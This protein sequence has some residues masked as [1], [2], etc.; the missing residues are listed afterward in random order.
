MI[1]SLT[2]SSSS[3]SDAMGGQLDATNN[4]LKEGDWNINNA[5][6]SSAGSFAMS[7]KNMMYLAAAAVVAYVL[8][9]NKKAA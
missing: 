4:A 3:K 9:K 8:F 6:N 1:P 2:L 7:K 5:P